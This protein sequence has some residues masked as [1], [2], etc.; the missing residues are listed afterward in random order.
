MRS[1]RVALSTIFCIY[2]LHIELL[3]AQ[4]TAVNL[5]GCITP[6]NNNIVADAFSITDEFVLSFRYN[7]S[8]TP[9]QT[10]ANLFGIFRSNGA[11]IT[12]LSVLNDQGLLNFG[13]I[14]VG[15]VYQE[16]LVGVEV[17]VIIHV[18]ANEVLLIVDGDEACNIPRRNA[19]ALGNARDLT[20]RI[21][22]NVVSAPGE[23]CDLQINN[24][25]ADRYSYHGEVCFAAGASLPEAAFT[26]SVNGHIDGIR[27]VHKSGCLTCRDE[28]QCA[29]NWGCE[30]DE[31]GV[32]DLYVIVTDGNGGTDAII[33]PAETDFGSTS[34]Y[35][36][37]GF[38]AESPF[39]DL[40]SRTPILV[41]NGSEYVVRYSEVYLNNLN[42]VHNI[43]DN[44]G[45]TCADVYLILRCPFEVDGPLEITHFPELIEENTHLAIDGQDTFF[46][47]QVN[48]PIQ[49]H[50]AR[51]S[52]QD[53]DE[54]TAAFESNA[55]VVSPFW[56]IQ[57]LACETI[58]TGRIP[59]DDFRRSWGG[60]STRTDLT[61]GTESVVISTVIEMTVERLVQ[62]DDGDG[63]TSSASLLV[64]FEVIFELTHTVSGTTNITTFGDVNGPIPSEIAVGAAI[65]DLSVVTVNPAAVDTGG[66]SPDYATGQLIFLTTLR[67][68]YMLRPLS[69]NT[70]GF[71]N[72][73][74]PT[75]LHIDANNSV[76]N[77]DGLPSGI[78]LHDQSQ[79]NLGIGGFCRQ[80]WRVSLTA[81]Q[82][83]LNGIFNA[84]MQIVCIEEERC[85]LLIP[86]ADVIQI[87]MITSSDSFCGVTQSID[88]HGEVAIHT[89][90]TECNGKFSASVFCSPGEDVS[91]QGSTFDLESV[92][93]LQVRA[94][95]RLQ[96]LPGDAMP[97]GSSAVLVYDDIPV[98]PFEFEVTANDSRS[99]TFEFVWNSAY[100]LCQTSQA[101]IE[102]VV[103]VVYLATRE[104]SL[105][106]SQRLL[107]TYDHTGTLAK[108]P[109]L[110]Q[111]N[112]QRDRS[113]YMVGSV[114]ILADDTSSTTQVGTNDGGG[115]PTWVVI[116]IAALT[117]SICCVICIGCGVIFFLF[118]RNQNR[119]YRTHG[120]SSRLGASGVSEEETHVEGE[121][122]SAAEIEVATR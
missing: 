3:N 121:P 10:A 73:G 98:A 75:F 9:R 32:D 59:W 80:Q 101:L 42:G 31:N 11:P 15:C 119:K 13:Y 34:S 46:Q 114:S 94:G 21:S 113:I 49:F 57:E 50:Y 56:E 118:K 39:L 45:T 89:N 64:P 107:L 55:S 81:G 112:E 90:P 63:I 116:L 86:P 103:E 43:S 38:N 2:F 62:I 8:E 27:L 83:T 28:V 48:V 41:A 35:Q 26:S 23:I 67:S 95:P 70:T 111:T 60:V 79:C 5:S 109:E 58:Y 82:C 4:Y 71:D 87:E 65:S 12:A 69:I 91:R 53:A 7:A 96:N 24:L 117:T 110:L 120:S 61:D 97:S 16:R 51:F 18:S 40:I 93:L 66:Q 105:L 92:T 47:V 25:P 20:L 115:L 108:A 72:S 6:T 78:F 17:D 85:A 104:L 54:A 52:F 88:V 102:I 77:R 84:F 19:L 44:N 74:D 100:L 22:G 29:S 37:A 14:N 30:V 36:I 33:L 76:T 106:E 122:S 68:P 99:V 1:L